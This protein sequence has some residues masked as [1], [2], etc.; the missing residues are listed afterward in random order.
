MVIFIIKEMLRE[1]SEAR[2]RKGGGRGRPADSRYL[3]ISDYAKKYAMSL[4]TV[5]K[6]CALGR[7]KFFT[8]PGGYRKVLDIPPEEPIEQK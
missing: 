3:K 7:C 5:E 1:S 4:K 6:L 8:T 2:S